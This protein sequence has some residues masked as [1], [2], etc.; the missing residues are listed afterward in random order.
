M[1]I[2]DLTPYNKYVN[3]EIIA[4]SLFFLLYCT[5]LGSVFCVSFCSKCAIRARVTG[6]SDIRTWS[7]SKG[8]GKLF[9]VELLDDSGEI[10]MTG[11]NQSVD[12][13][14]DMLEVCGM[15]NNN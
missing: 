2:R 9:N 1:P 7:N 13:F 15:W 4:T 10:K 8:E 11:F 6:K 5:K 3:F 14:Y 12:Q